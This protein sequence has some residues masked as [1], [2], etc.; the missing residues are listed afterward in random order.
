MES[1]SLNHLA[2]EVLRWRLLSRKFWPY[3]SPCTWATF[4]KE[5]SLNKDTMETWRFYSYTRDRNEETLHQA[6]W[7]LPPGLPASRHGTASAAIIL[8]SSL[9]GLWASSVGASTAPAPLI[10]DFAIQNMFPCRSLYMFYLVFLEMRVLG[11][12]GAIIL[13]KKVLLDQGSGPKGVCF[14]IFYTVHACFIDSCIWQ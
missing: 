14:L 10:L 9:P 7:L 5:E 12:W 6:S 4:P 13:Y 11:H 8:R 2:R 3:L 1:R